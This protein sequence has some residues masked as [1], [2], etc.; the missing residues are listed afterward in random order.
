MLY[1]Y[2]YRMSQSDPF[3]RVFLFRTI[4]FSLRVRDDGKL[5]MNNL[6]CFNK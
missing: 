3:P 6:L 5:K 2:E 4:I 1:I